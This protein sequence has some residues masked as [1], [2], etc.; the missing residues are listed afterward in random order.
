MNKDLKQVKEL[1]MW[2][3]REDALEIEEIA[4]ARTLSGN[5]TGGLAKRLV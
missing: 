2:P 4:N 5:V 3:C 1:A